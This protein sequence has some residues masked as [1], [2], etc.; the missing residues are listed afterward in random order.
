MSDWRPPGWLWLSLRLRPRLAVV[1]GG[2]AALGALEVG[3]IE[4][5]SRRGIVPDLLVGTSIGAVNA[6][7]WAFDPR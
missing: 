2:G 4:T 7:F 3:I 5:L 6:A 1:L